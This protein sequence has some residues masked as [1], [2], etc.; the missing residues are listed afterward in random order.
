[1][2]MGTV[3]ASNILN[4]LAEPLKNESPVA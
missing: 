3:A 2:K 1:V 4:V